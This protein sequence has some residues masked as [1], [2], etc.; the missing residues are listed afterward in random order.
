MSN[1]DASVVSINECERIR[2]KEHIEFVL[3]LNDEHRQLE[4]DKLR[5]ALQRSRGVG[6]QNLLELD[7]RPR[8]ETLKLARDLASENFPKEWNQWSTHPTELLTLG[9]SYIFNFRRTGFGE[10]VNDVRRCLSEKDFNKA[11]AKIMAHAKKL[12]GFSHCEYGDIHPDIKTPLEHELQMQILRKSLERSGL[13]TD[14]EWWI[15][16]RDDT[17]SNLRKNHPVDVQAGFVREAVATGISLFGIEVS[18]GTVPMRD[19][20]EGIT[21]EHRLRENMAALRLDAEEVM[22]V[23]GIDPKDPAFD[24]FWL[25]FTPVLEG[26]KP[27]PF[28]RKKEVREMLRAINIPGLTKDVIKDLVRIHNTKLSALLRSAVMWGLSRMP[29]WKAEDRLLRCQ[30]NGLDMVSNFDA[31]NTV[32]DLEWTTAL[33]VKAGLFISVTYVTK[34]KLRKEVEGDLERLKCIVDIAGEQLVSLRCKDAAG[35]VECDF[36]VPLATNCLQALN[37]WEMDIPLELHT[38]EVRGNSLLTMVLWALVVCN[39]SQKPRKAILN[40]GVA[41]MEFGQADLEKVARMLK[42]SGVEGDCKYDKV[43]W[44]KS[45]NKHA[46]RVRTRMLKQ[47]IAQRMFV[48]NGASRQWMAAAPYPG[49]ALGSN[50]NHMRDSLPNFGKLYGIPCEGAKKRRLDFQ[51]LEL[52]N[53]VLQLICEGM[54]QIDRIF[55]GMEIVTPQAQRTITLS[56]LALIFMAAKGQFDPGLI[57]WAGNGRHRS[58]DPSNPQDILVIPK[59]HFDPYAGVFLKT[60]LIEEHWASYSPDIDVLHQVVSSALGDCV[61]RGF[62]DSFDARSESSREALREEL[63]YLG[64]LTSYLN[65]PCVDKGVIKAAKILKNAGLSPEE[66]KDFDGF[67]FYTRV[68][69]EMKTE[70]H[71]RP[72][73][74]KLREPGMTDEVFRNV[75]CYR[76]QGAGDKLW[77]IVQEQ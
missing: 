17:Q 27:R 74:E 65:R 54:V 76:E 29:D 63:A 71:D 66:P 41:G 16:Y 25:R 28:P 11:A 31:N 3:T 45:W 1:Q 10:A 20:F 2:L 21:D 40:C 62:F 36:V 12:V 37:K 72:R 75:V 57:K 33:C 15:T 8:T 55:G 39:M 34:P 30:Q 19:K 6:L 53:A 60:V 59:G 51:E 52:F 69:D 68:P 26:D 48:P 13:K 47:R 18:G 50:D 14:V 9:V 58:R 5:R 46:K 73:A 4:V 49:G 61:P 38:H 77:D 56:H 22:R 42:D 24:T 32:F 7:K 44:S 43:R 67:D 64:P 70:F 23:A 35:A